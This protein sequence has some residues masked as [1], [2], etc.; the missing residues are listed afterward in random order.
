MAQDRE[1]GEM[2]EA[3]GEAVFWEREGEMA[4][5]WKVMKATCRK[6]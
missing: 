2:K 3:G 6:T 1:A 4:M 5:R